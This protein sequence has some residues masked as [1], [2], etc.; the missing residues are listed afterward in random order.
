M[1]AHLRF[2][3]AGALHFLRKERATPWMQIPVTGKTFF[4]PSS[5]RTYSVQP[6]G[7]S[8]VF[9][10]KRATVP[11]VVEARVFFVPRPDR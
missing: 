10:K 3:A 6:D 9:R 2:K 8:H 1:P 4:N 11:P 7:I 5:E